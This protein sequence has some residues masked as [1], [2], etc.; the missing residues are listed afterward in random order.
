MKRYSI[1]Q[2]WTEKNC[3]VCGATQNLHIHEVFFGTANRQLS[4]KHGLCV[5]LCSRHHNGSNEG[6]H[7][8]R[9]LDKKLKAHAQSIAMQKNNWTVD[10]FRKIFGKSFL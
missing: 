9:T 7:F 8:N 6:V 5:C 1:I 10:D 3:I 2:D 4:I